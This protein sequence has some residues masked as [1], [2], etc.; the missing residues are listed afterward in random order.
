MAECLIDRLQQH[1]LKDK[2]FEKYII[3][4]QKAFD[5]GNQCVLVTSMSNATSPLFRQ[6]QRALALDEEEG[7]TPPMLE[8]PPCC[9]DHDV[10]W[11]GR[12]PG[13]SF[14]DAGIILLM[15]EL[16]HDHQDMIKAIKGRFTDKAFK[17][18]DSVQRC[19]QLNCMNLFHGFFQRVGH[20]FGC[21]CAQMARGLV[22]NGKTIDLECSDPTCVSY[23]KPC[24]LYNSIMPLAQISVQ[25]FLLLNTEDDDI[26]KLSRELIGLELEEWSHEFADLELKDLQ[27]ICRLPDGTPGK[28]VPHT[29]K[30]AL[31]DAMEH[32][33]RVK[34]N[35]KHSMV[36]GA[37]PVFYAMFRRDQ[38]FLSLD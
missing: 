33:P 5:R 17:M 28:W 25:N 30:E 6:M 19:H 12:G 8:L 36:D 20:K 24:L 3:L 22:R 23:G 38:P 4:C 31:I 18:W 37:L 13:L 2:N 9:N 29:L 21:L 35:F 32:R 26:S 15:L 11:K 27:L 16:K 7:L 1:A 34:N 10:P 14:V